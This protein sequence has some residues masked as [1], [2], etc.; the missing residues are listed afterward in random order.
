MKKWSN[1]SKTF[2]LFLK[3]DSSNNLYL[4]G[5]STS[6]QIT[7]NSITYSGGTTGTTNGYLLKIDPTGTIIYFKWI[8]GTSSSNVNVYAL[9]IDTSNNVIIGFW[10]TTQNLTI[11]GTVFT[12]AGP[13]TNSGRLE[14]TFIVKFNSAGVVQWIKSIDGNSNDY[15]FTC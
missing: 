7:F 14:T 6:T 8:V 4:C 9:D 5:M 12:N 3:M 11:G 1:F 13:L 15:I 2:G 10:G